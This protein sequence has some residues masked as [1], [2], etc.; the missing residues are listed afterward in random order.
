MP[1]VAQPFD[2]LEFDVDGHDCAWWTLDQM[3][4]DPRMLA[5]NGDLLSTLELIETG[6]LPVPSARAAAQGTFEA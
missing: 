1:V 4:A 3:L 6:L 2:R 5:V